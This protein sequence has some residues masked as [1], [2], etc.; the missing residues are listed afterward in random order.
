MTSGTPV[1]PLLE[2]AA[3]H[4][5][6]MELHQSAA[7]AADPTAPLHARLDAYEDVFESQ[8]GDSLFTRA[9]NLER[10]FGLRQLWLKFEGDNPTGTQ[11]DRIAFAQTA[12]ALRRGFD[13]VT[14]ATCGNYGVALA[15]AARL[16]GLR[17]VA[18]IPEPYHTKRVDEMRQLGA[19]I[20][21]AGATYEDA[22]V[23]STN[24][25]Q[26]HGWYDANPGGEN[27][28]VQLKAYGE[29][30]FE[31]YDQL[32]DAPALVAAPMSNGTT[33]AGLHRGFKSLFRRGKTSKL[34][35]MVGGSAWKKN[36]IVEAFDKGLDAC[37]QLDPARIHETVVNEPL[38]NWSSID[39]DLALE[40]I[41]STGGFAAGA[42]DR[43]MRD[44]AR[45]LKEQQALHVLPASTAGLLA[46]LELHARS[47]LPPDR[48]VVVLTGRYA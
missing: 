23:H 10:T 47:P 26:A 19:D 7:L 48:Y 32:R 46:L 22:V 44:M 42:S 14:V 21:R 38:I 34:P 12:D 11:K 28:L 33:L 13:T 8:V 5:E 29:M 20:A 37:P 1:R 15:L 24:E 35:R 43:K 2:A 36:P 18:V 6:A 41:R 31:I 39:G 9:R 25:A 4:L 30:S 3:S 16:A 17:C 40:A 45:L 27:E